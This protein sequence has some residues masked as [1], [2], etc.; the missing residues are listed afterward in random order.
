MRLKDFLL[1]T[2][3]TGFGSGFSPIV[4]GTAGSAVATVLVWLL[5]P[6]SWGWQALICLLTTAVSIYAAGWLAESLNLED[7][8]IV[9][10]DE[11]SGQFIT[12]LGLG[13]AA[14]ADWRV[15]LLGF[16][17]FRALDILK[18]GPIRRL[19]DLPGGWGIVMDDVLAGFFANILLRVALIWM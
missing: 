14:L 4:P 6:A 9:V 10:A 2:T 11:F 8:S 7:P 13:A 12:F 3:A 5:W 16:L 17:L 1:Y 15:L 19:E 18:P